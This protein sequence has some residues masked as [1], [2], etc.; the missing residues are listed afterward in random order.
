M[1]GPL[2]LSFSR[3]SIFSAHLFLFWPQ[4]SFNWG[5]IFTEYSYCQ[6]FSQLSD[7]FFLADP[8]CFC[9][10]PEPGLLLLGWQGKAALQRAQALLLPPALPVWAGSRGYNLL[11]VF[12]LRFFC[13]FLIPQGVTN[14]C[15]LSL[16]ACM[17]INTTPF[18]GCIS[19]LFASVMREFVLFYL[20]SPLGSRI[21]SVS[22]KM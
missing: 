1:Q 13:V 16:F 12:S 15:Q 10:W 4:F 2:H 6:F 3:P 17:T 19:F 11:S 22:R 8:W 18:I 14:H 21:G 5:L 20:I 7:P 9:W